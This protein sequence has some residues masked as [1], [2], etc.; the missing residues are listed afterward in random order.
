MR[1]V[2][3]S[4]TEAHRFATSFAAAETAGGPRGDIALDQDAAGAGDLRRSLGQVFHAAR[5]RIERVVAPVL[6]ELRD[7]RDRRQTARE[8]RRLSP[9]LLADIGIEPDEI[10]LV[11]DARLAAS[12]NVTARRISP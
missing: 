2:L 12:R 6:H 5:A 3:S 1:A 10:E 11:V 8:L 7:V 9:A 4:R